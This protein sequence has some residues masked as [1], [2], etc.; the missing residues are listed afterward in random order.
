MD[1]LL[2]YL[3]QLYQDDQPRKVQRAELA[4]KVKDG[5]AACQRLLNAIE[6]G[7]EAPGL[8][9]ERLR[10]RQE[11][12]VFAKAKLEQLDAQATSSIP[13]TREQ[14]IEKIALMAKQ[15]LAMDRE[16]G[17][18]L[19]RLVSPIRAVPHRQFGGNKV[20]LRAKFEL[21]LAALLPDQFLPALQGV[22]AEAGAGGFHVIPMTVDLFESSAGPK[23]FA[24]ALNLSKAGVTLEEIGK[25]RFAKRQA[26]IAVQYG[27]DLE[28]AGLTDLFIELTEEPA[29]ASR[30]RTHRRLKKSG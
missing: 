15:L 30:W 2:E 6:L 25:Q 13:P 22:H 27:R 3:Q 10:Q 11:E 21:R 16:T 23:H 17:V 26:H 28:A 20:V 9:V 24:E 5:E 1:A 19:K 7:K 12:V 29:E 8:V 14:I 18:V 4:A